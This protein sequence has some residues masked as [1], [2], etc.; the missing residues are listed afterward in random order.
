VTTRNGWYAAFADISKPTLAH[1]RSQNSAEIVATTN[2][3]RVIAIDGLNGVA[4]WIRQLNPRSGTAPLAIVIRDRS[5]LDDVF[6]LSGAAAFLF[7]GK[8]GRE[9]WHGSL[10]GAVT[11]AVAAG[12]KVFAIESSLQRAFLVDASAAKLI[13]DV[14]LPARVV[15]VPAFTND[16]G[17]PSVVIALEDGRLQAFDEQGKLIRSGD[18]T[19]TITTGPLFVRTPGGRLTLVGT[20]NGLT[21]LNAEDLRPLGRVT[22]KD[23]PRGSL[24]AQDLD[25]DGIAEIVLFTDGGRVVVVK[26]G[27]GKVIWEA[28][29][30]RADAASF[31][32]VNSDR[33]VD[34]LMTGRE[35]SAFALSGSDG[36][37]IWKDQ[38]S[39]QIV[40]NHAPAIAPRSS[41]VVST[42]T[43]VLFIVTDAGR[44]G[45]RALEFPRTVAPRN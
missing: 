5:G 15:G 17:S 13:A 40:T 16:L 28:D 24:F 9:I 20:R 38:S 11:T 37:V 21:A 26:S 30:K 22:L 6:V 1:L 27:E 7:D 39:A 44:G 18:A 25:N 35:G 2:D 45:L 34:L 23:S 12:D 8:T 29:A 14:H 33:V 31:A 19:T 43:G 42:P 10:P 32:D 3:N 4:L 41:L 36:S